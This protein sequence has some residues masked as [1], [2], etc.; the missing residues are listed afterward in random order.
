[1]L[2][3]H[4]NGNGTAHP[5]ATRMTGPPSQ[6]LRYVIVVG[7]LALVQLAI[8]LAEAGGIHRGAASAS[9]ALNPSP[10]TSHES[11]PVL[12]PH[13]ASTATAPHRAALPAASAKGRARRLAWFGNGSTPFFAPDRPVPRQVLPN[14][15][16]MVADDLQPKVAYRFDIH[17]QQPMP[18]R[19]PLTALGC[20][21]VGVGFAHGRT[22]RK[23]TPQAFKPL[24]TSALLM[25]TRPCLMAHACTRR[26]ATHSSSHE[27]T[28]CACARACNA[29]PA[30]A[31]MRTV[32]AHRPTLECLLMLA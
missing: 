19:Q 3:R 10:V 6:R 13:T 21:V 16:L 11:P 25:R 9:A 1:M 23:A 32:P 15:L 22:Y 4:T 12:P 8:L 27:Y 26:A 30:L 5:R 18:C 28:H 7:L 17:V 31:P 29:N 14:I 24:G 2:S 20:C